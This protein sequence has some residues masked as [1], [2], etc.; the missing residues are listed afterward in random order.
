MPKKPSVSKEAVKMQ[1][2]SKTSSRKRAKWSRAVYGYPLKVF[3]GV[4]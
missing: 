4:I 3:I 1:C 2:L